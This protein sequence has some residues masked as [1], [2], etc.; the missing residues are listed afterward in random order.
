MDNI[1]KVPVTTHAVV[2]RF[3]GDSGDGIQ[4]VGEQFTDSSA[5]AGNDISTFP[6]FPAEIRAPQGTLPGVSGFQ[7]Q[8]GSTEIR[9]PG[10]APDA[11]VAM[12]P[13]ALKVNLAS[14]KPKGLL[15]VNEAAFKEA[16]LLKAGYTSNPLDDEALKAMYQVIP[17]NMSQLTKD[18]LL[19][20]PL[21][22]SEKLK[23][24]NFL[25]L[26]FIYWIY[27]R[28]LE[29]TEQWIKAKWGSKQDV[30]DANITA[31]R[32]GRNFAE[33][34][35]YI[36]NQYHVPKA[37]VKPGYYRKI[38]GNEAMVI[39]LATGA[40]LHGKDLVIGSYPITPATGI[41]EGLAKHKRFG[42]KS[43]QMEDEIAAI[44]VAIGASY[45]GALG[46][47]TTSGPGICLKSEFMNL[48]VMTELPVIIVNVQ[49]AGP[50]TGLPTKTEQ[51]DLLQVMYGRNGDSPI[52]ILAAT[53]PADCFETAH[54]AIRIALTYNTP[55]VILSDGYIANGSEPW[56]IPSESSLKKYKHP[57]APLNQ[58]YIPYAR[59]PVTLA[60]TLAFPGQPGL[61]HRIGGLEKNDT[62][63]VDYDGLNH[64]RMVRL[65]QQKI[66]GIATTYPATKIFG[67][68][69]GKVLVLSWGGTTGS[70][71]TAV[72]LLQ[73]Q[74]QHVSSV[75]L[76]YIYP[77]PKDLS[78]ILHS[79]DRVIIPE[80]NTGQL[81]KIIRA[82]YLID[83]ISFSKVQGRPFEVAEL[84]SKISEL[85]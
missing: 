46:L 35:E 74:G 59:D 81:N 32:A 7:I 83:T 22:S 53:S 82:E 13:A 33:I 11:L 30:V 67:K 31:L 61:E 51:S 40:R 6:D 69:K 48:A 79:F 41:L 24:Q 43:I 34:C 64:E 52:P 9:T 80:L 49:R 18:A 44:G 71:Q 19:D 2:I 28:S 75:A 10:D 42:V 12:N 36:P 17:V 27:S 62:G 3:A 14:L 63:A 23:C 26:G 29:H 20:S 15:V 45:A 37:K 60:R 56:L 25:A 16:N 55:I 57:S 8:F 21:K 4:T 1:V 5:L 76:R 85:L 47:T 50:S 58:K 84:V 66:E 72:E 38:T 73:N 70:V 77:L 78:G 54:E 65:R 39:G 68:A